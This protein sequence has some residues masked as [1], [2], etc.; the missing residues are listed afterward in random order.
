MVIY[1]LYLPDVTEGYEVQD[2][3]AS[4]IKLIAQS[5]NTIA[6][7]ARKIGMIFNILNVETIWQI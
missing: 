4:F 6:M 3:I 7:I 2:L 1:N 5:K